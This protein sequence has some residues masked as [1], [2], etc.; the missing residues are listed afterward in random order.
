[1][2]ESLLVEWA[3]HDV[4]VLTLNRPERRNAVDPEL[5]TALTSALLT[6]GARA[7]A[8]ILRG[9]GDS[10]F[11]AGYDISRLTGSI[12]D[13]DADRYIGDAASGLRT[14]PA[15][16]VAQL[17]G[18]CHG[19][20]VELALSCDLRIAGDDLRLSVPAVSLGVVYRYQFVARL[21]QISGMARASD[22]LLAMP[23]LDA[24]RALAW[25]LVSEVVPASEIAAR[26]AHLAERLAKSPPA[27]VRGTKASL[28]LLAA[29]AALAEDVQ[30]AQ[31]LRA[32]AAGSP[33]RR[34][35]VR[36]RQ[37]AISRR[38][39]PASS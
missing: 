8:V 33:E 9:A 10:A 36:R 14:C 37:Q 16:V 13:L 3:Q 4:L 15:P 11:C 7:S 27:A 19:A 26:V 28:N 12:E 39:R 29:R 21:V 17:N 5:L 34:D 31:Q 38:S 25:G 35:A 1:M 20:G 23:E 30:R 18:H 32:H 6:E 2:T 22:L 24:G